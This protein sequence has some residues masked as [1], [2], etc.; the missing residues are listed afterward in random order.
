MSSEQAA[1]PTRGSRAACDRLVRW[2]QNVVSPR[3]RMKR[4]VQARPGLNGQRP[5]SRRWQWCA[6]EQDCVLPKFWHHTW[7][8]LRCYYFCVPYWWKKLHKTCCGTL[9]KT[10]KWLFTCIQNKRKLPNLTLCN[11]SQIIKEVVLSTFQNQEPG[12]RNRR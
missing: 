12:L 5:E 11:V 10:L 9:H 4:C 2:I 3:L 7:H 8:L 6:A 1:W